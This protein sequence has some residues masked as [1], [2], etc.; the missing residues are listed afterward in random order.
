MQVAYNNGT[1]TQ[2]EIV[3]VPEPSTVSIV[4]AGLGLLGLRRQRRHNRSV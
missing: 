3:P 4:A 2:F 1:S